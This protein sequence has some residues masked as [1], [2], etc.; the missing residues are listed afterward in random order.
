MMQVSDSIS[1]SIVRD[2]FLNDA[3]GAISERPFLVAV[4]AAA[5]TKKRVEVYAHAH[6]HTRTRT[7]TCAHAHTHTCTHAHAHA[8]THTAFDVIPM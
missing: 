3:A 5:D 2:V 8:H 4:P 1:N 7:H 6:A